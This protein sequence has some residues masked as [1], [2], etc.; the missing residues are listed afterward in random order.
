[1]LNKNYIKKGKRLASLLVLTLTAGLLAGVSAC[2][3]AGEAEKESGSGTA[4]AAKGRFMEEIVEV[5][6]ELQ[7]SRLVDAI[8]RGN[9]MEFLFAAG[10]ESRVRYQYDGNEWT[11]LG[12]VL[13][14][15]GIFPDRMV[16]GQDGRLYYGGFGEGYVYHLWTAD[17]AGNAEEILPEIFKVKEGEDYGLTPDYFAVLE[18]GSILVSDYQQAQLYQ[19]DGR[20]GSVVAQ[21]FTGSNI[22]SSAWL[23]GTE[24]LTL[25]GQRIVR[26]DIT[27]GRQTGDFELPGHRTSTEESIPLFTAEDGTVYAASRE[28]LYRTEQNG[29]LWEQIIDG[30]LNSMGRQDLSLFKFFMGNDGDYYGISVDGSYQLNL[31]R[32]YY[33]DEIATVPPET[34]TIYSLRDNATIR[35][36]ASIFQSQNPQVRVDFRSAVQEQE[37]AVSEDIIRA[38]NTELLNGKGADILILDGL[39]SEA[40]QNKGILADMS[41]IFSDI[42]GELLP[43]VVQ[44]FTESDGAVYRMPARIKVPV[45]LGAPAAVEAMTSFSAMERYD[46]TPPLLLTDNYE[47]ILRLTASVNFLTLFRED[48]SIENGTLSAWLSAVKSAGEKGNAR[49]EF[50]QSEIKELGIDN[51]VLP[52]GFGR[53]SEFAVASGESPVGVSLLDSLDSAGMMITAEPYVQREISLIQNMYIPSVTVGLNAA[54]ENREAAERF[55]HTLFSSEIQNEALYDG[56]PVR[57]DSLEAWKEI[58]KDFSWV[59]SASNS[60]FEL[61]GE[62]PTLPERERILE[63]VKTVEIPA[64]INQQIMQMV[65]DGSKDYFNGKEPLERA[66]SAIESKIRLYLSELE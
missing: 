34:L 25:S 49:V 66:V 36:A 47:N 31:F 52:N 57:S 7:D 6:E 2:S 19:P 9:Q 5:P 27:T 60:G 53:Q 21:D 58:Q 39:P 42:D 16:L 56:F 15:N 22:R 4:A 62:W 64:E 55:I 33:D 41:G 61:T 40:Y 13:T 17:D 14:L 11:Q 44:G 20:Q 28:G 63:L 32:Y 45:M 48:G 29:T 1:M 23:M 54:S 3:P 51:N 8:Q 37:E 26:Y 24:Y 50:S 35:Q 12:D 38:L 30:S 65:V 10:D 18:D 46:G 43:N 59:F